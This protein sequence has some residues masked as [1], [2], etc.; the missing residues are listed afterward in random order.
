MKNIPKIRDVKPLEN[1]SI[2][3]LFEN[4]IQK[5]YNVKALMGKYPVFKDLRDNRLFRLVHVDCGG[6]GIAWND[7]IDLSEYEIWENG[8]DI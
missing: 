2:K 6:Y 3:V 7:Y 1:Y 4:G 8:I 5:E